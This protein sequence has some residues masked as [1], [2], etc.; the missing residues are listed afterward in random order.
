MKKTSILLTLLILLNCFAFST[1]AKSTNNIS[2]S[3]LSDRLQTSI[4]KLTDND[5]IDVT[6]WL[7]DYDEDVYKKAYTESLEKAYICGEIKTEVGVATN[8]FNSSITST[9]NN[10]ELGEMQQLL[11]IKQN[12]HK[13]IISQKNHNWYKNIK[14]DLS[15]NSKIIYSSNYAPVVIMRTTKSDLDTLCKS[16]DIKH[17]YEWVGNLATDSVINP[18]PIS[19]TTESS[20]TQNNY[21]VWQNITNI[22][23][24]RNAMG[25]TG[26]KY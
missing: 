1:Q 10:I 11:S 16:K 18:A 17:I 26:K 12:S 21:G 9:N 25:Y 19:T 13:E 5:T 4:S 23:T 20:T 6:L 2:L 22:H 24:L 8:L 14:S 3:K 15:T 7:D